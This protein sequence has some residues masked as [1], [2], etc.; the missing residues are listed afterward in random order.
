MDESLDISAIEETMHDPNEYGC[1]ECRY[2]TQFKQNLKRHKKIHLQNLPKS[3]T[4]IKPPTATPTCTATSTISSAESHKKHICDQCAKEFS[5]KY[6][7]TLH[8]K[9]KHDNVFKFICQICQKGFNQATQYR[10]HCANH[11]N[12]SFEKCLH[13]KK[14]FRSPGCLKKHL[15]VCKDNPDHQDVG[16]F[17]CHVCSASFSA[18][19]SLSYHRQGKHQPPRYQCK[20]CP[21]AYAW[22]SSLRAH[23]KFAHSN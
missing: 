7:L 16:K 6:G 8:K 22:R 15:S 1:S 21:K 4:P 17:V 13:C 11:L 23:I 5:T 2:K 18:K 19:H 12:V 14:E 20:E 9:N 10:F 3:S